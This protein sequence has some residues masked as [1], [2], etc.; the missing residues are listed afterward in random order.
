MISIK[1]VVVGVI[2]GVSLL[3]SIPFLLAKDA[4]L[5]QEQRVRAIYAKIVGASGEENMAPKLTIA[6]EPIVN[7]YATQTGIV[8][9][10]GIIK[11]TNSDDEIA[12]ILGHELAHVM[13]GHVF[14]DEQVPWYATGRMESQA[15]KMGAYYMMRAGFDICKGRLFWLRAAKEG[16]YLYGDHPDYAY[17][18][19]QLNI[20]CDK[21]GL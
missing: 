3:V 2:M 17:R 14:I 1:N 15:D 5:T 7:A 19:S 8:I 21:D 10:T 4:P 16:N 20:N 6:D 13:L 18:F 9:Y 12:L 11:A